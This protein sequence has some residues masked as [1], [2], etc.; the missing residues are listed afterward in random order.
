MKTHENFVILK[1]GVSATPE[2]VRRVVLRTL[3]KYNKD[4]FKEVILLRKNNAYK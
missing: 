2:G 1:T 3:K 4:L